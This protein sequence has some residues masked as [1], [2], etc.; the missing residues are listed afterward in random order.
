MQPTQPVEAVRN[1]KNGK[2]FI[3][4]DDTL[5]ARYKV[6]NPAGEMLILPDLL[7]DEDP[8]TVGPDAMAESFSPEQLSALEKFLE[9][10]AAEAARPPPPPRR[11][12]VVAEEAPKSRRPLSKAV[13]KASPR[14]GLGAQWSAP[15]LSF[16][17]HKIE[18][19]SLKQTFRIMVDGFGTFELS[20]EDF[21]A[22]FN[23]VVMSPSY[24]KDGL[25]TYPD[26]PEKAMRFL[27]RP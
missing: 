10:Q 2:L 14:V 11:E 16:Y 24:R 20:K 9:K 4:L 5:E 13:P 3:I 7:F 23:D 25:Y 19:L 21:L 8:V 27:K 22:L 12:V 26:V 1:R 15:R 18:P 17:K 6:I